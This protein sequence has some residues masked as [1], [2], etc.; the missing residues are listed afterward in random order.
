MEKY[1]KLGPRSSGVQHSD[2]TRPLPA[3]TEGGAAPLV[4][5]LISHHSQS[6]KNPVKSLLVW[7]R[8]VKLVRDFQ[9][10]PS[11][12]PPACRSE[13]SSFS[14]ASKSR[15]KFT[16]ANA[17]PELISQFAMTYHHA[18]PDGRTIKH[19]LDTFLKSLRHR[20]PNVRYLWIL[21]FQTRNTPHFHLFL[22]LPHG[23]ASLHTFMAEKWHSIAEPESPQHLKFHAH[24]KNFIPWDMGSAGYLCKYL[25]KE[26]QKAVPIGYTGVGRFWGNTR[27]LVPAA[28]E[29]EMSDI[30]NAFSYEATNYL[31]GEVEEF[32]ASEYVTRQLC[33]HHEHSLK[34]SKWKSSARTRPTCYTFQNAAKIYTSLESYLARQDRPQDTIPF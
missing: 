6:R 31:T 13:I 23:T 32:K 25:D 18:Q 22:S 20:F 12:I 34:R 2:D 4:N 15:L 9:G 5:T 29:V 16:A 17:F 24:K 27:G 33:R 28:I 26:A 11:D 21:E 30:D 3:L 8:A 14:Q 19:H 7:P 1:Q 10:K